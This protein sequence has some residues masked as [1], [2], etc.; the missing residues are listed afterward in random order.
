M[1]EALPAI[2]FSFPVRLV[3]AQSDSLENARLLRSRQ[4]LPFFFQKIKAGKNLT[5]GY[6]GGSITEAGKGWREQSVQG[7]QKRYPKAQFSGINAGVGGT[8]SDLGVFRV[9]P[10][11]LDQKPDLVF[12]E[13]AVNDNGKKPEQI[14]RAMEGIVRKIWR[15]NPQIDICFVYTITADLAPYFQRGKL[16][17]SALAMEQIAEHYGVPSVCMG[18]KVAALAKEGT[19]LFKGKRE[20]HPDKIVFSADNVHPYAETGHALYAEALDEALQQLSSQQSTLKAHLLPKPYVADHW[21]A[22]RMVPFEQLKRQGNWQVLTPETDTVARLMKNRFTRLLKSTQPGDYLEV[23]MKGQAC[24]LYDVMGPGCGQYVLELDSDYQQKIDRF[25]AYCTYYRS[26]FFVLPIDPQK[27][28]TFRFRVSGEK[29]D[30]A[31]ILKARNE[32]IDEPRRYE[33]NACYAGQLLLVGELI[34]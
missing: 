23:R 7:L 5:I 28:H 34:P 20:E 31:K 33:E 13:F 8:G 27:E 1:H 3:R 32:T 19:L 26:N 14:Y 15:Q 12:V 21:E 11:I 10:Q 30:K 6:L 16:P 2:L 4:G 18:L 22:A 9:Q 24:G 17:P 29:L 25:D